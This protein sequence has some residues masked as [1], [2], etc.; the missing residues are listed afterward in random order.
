M[1]NLVKLAGDLQGVLRTSAEHLVKLA[2]QNAELLAINEQQSRE[3]MAMK[4]ARRMEQRGLSTELDFE[5]KVAM[6]LETPVEKL[7]T[8]EQ[9]IELATGGFRLGSVQADDKMAGTTE[10]GARTPD[11]LDS[12]VSSQ[13]AY[14]T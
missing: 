6:L 9:A 13:T 2:N 14:T 3:L 8:M 4:L 11:D 5:E 10:Y 1:S 7:A 12:Y